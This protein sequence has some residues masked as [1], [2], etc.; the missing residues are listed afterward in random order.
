MYLGNERQV[1]SSLARLFQ[2]CGHRIIEV[3]GLNPIFN[4]NAEISEASGFPVS[5]TGFDAHRDGK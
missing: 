4:G 2:V 5:A 1:V 3:S